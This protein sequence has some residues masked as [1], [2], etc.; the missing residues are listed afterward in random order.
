[1]GPHRI[2]H[3]RKGY[4]TETV[5]DAA[6]GRFVNRPFPSPDTNMSQAPSRLALDPT[7]DA[8]QQTLASVETR[9]INAHASH[10]GYPYNLTQGAGAPPDLARFLI[11]NLG[12]P[13]V[14]SH[15]ASEV[16][17]LE[18]E[19]IDWIKRLWDC[20]DPAG[21]WGSVGASGTEGN[22]W[23]MFLGREALPKATLI[24]SAEAHYSIPKAARILRIK[25]ESVACTSDGA[26]DLDVL[27]HVLA[28]QRPGHGVILAVTCGTTVKGAHD[29]IAGAVARL[30]AAGFS[31]E[32]R[33]VHVDGALNAMVLPF[34]D[35]V[36]PRLRPSFR[37]GIDSIST[38]GH[39]MIGCPMP[40]G[41]L[42]A[43]RSHVARVSRA[44]A[45][46]RSDDTTLMGSR[47]GHAV[48]DLWVRL[49]SHGA[50]GFRRD[51][52]TCLQRAHW[53]A[54]ALRMAG[55]PVL[56][57]P[58]ALTVIFP[59]PEEHIVRHYQLACAR[60]QAHA[61]VMPNVT[62]AQVG[63]F[64]ADYLRWWA[65]EEANLRGAAACASDIQDTSVLAR[66]D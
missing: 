14:G 23:A 37:H 62:Q 31:A 34:L 20:D 56:H 13:Y 29:D 26:I 48:L 18:R 58:H 35:G 24:H 2:L 38:S 41:I 9:M 47:N 4:V 19:V 54:D 50:E 10:L 45:Y 15:Y 42:V 17:D 65:M 61:I 8:M 6:S 3:N 36:E 64:A 25:A 40:C 44:V 57:N 46:L 53:L 11:N 30:E 5:F 59:E 60:G 1:M 22:L 12:D 7:A 51:A 66:L 33:F 63:S 28:R 27:S 16:C 43:R 39:K 32:R 49:F 21:F 55:V 52:T